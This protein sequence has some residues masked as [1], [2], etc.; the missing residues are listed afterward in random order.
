M[1][2]GFALT[3]FAAMSHLSLPV[4]GQYAP[5]MEDNTAMLDVPGRSGVNSTSWTDSY[6]IGNSCYCQTSFDHNI[7]DKIVTTPLGQVTVREVCELLGD[8]PGGSAGRPLYNDIQCGNG[9]PNDAGDEGDCPGRVEYGKTGCK[10][11][12]PKWNFDDF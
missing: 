4:F 7:G 5:L 2:F 8:G 9:P 10:Y 3:L 1:R 11:I 12:G 6:S